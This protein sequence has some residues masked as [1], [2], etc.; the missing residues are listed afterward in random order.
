MPPAPI[1]RPLTITTWIVISVVVLVGSP[2]LLV[3]G[4]VAS[5][6]RRRREPLLWARFL[7]AYCARE[8]AVLVACGALWLWSGFGVRMRTARFQQLH[9]RLLGWFLH[10]LSA[11]ALDLLGVGV[12]PGRS[13]EA[14]EALCQDQP[15]LFFSRHAGPGD[16]LLI[17]DRLL[18]E[19]N[20][21]PR[22]VFKDALTLDPC[23]DL[24]G[25]RL[26]NAVLDTSE[27]EESERRIE[28]VTSGLPPRGVL[29]LFPEG[30]NYSP[31]RRRRALRKLWQKRRRREAQAAERM[32]NVMPPH[33]TGALAALRSRP[34]ADVVFAAHTGLG[35]AATAAELWRKLPTGRTLKSR[36]WLAPASERPRD[37]DE[38]V[39]WLYGW[40]KRLDEWIEL[41]GEE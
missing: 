34:E 28:E 5:A 39:K 14:E 13:P 9:Y 26:P 4:L 15:L 6:V 37:P 32:E 11:R 22:V 38:Q 35:L 19:Y 30:G 29:M 24:I 7:I 33:P 16:T 18:T 25:Y 1:R 41:Q 27:R 2:L 31:R 36:M 12:A 8:L 40:W 21:L 10:S 3:L 23:L 20:R 17:V